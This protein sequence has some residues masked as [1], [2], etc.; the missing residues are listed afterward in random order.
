MA[1]TNWIKLEYLTL[2]GWRSIND[3]EDFRPTPVNVLIGPNGA[4]K[5]NFI[6]F[7]NFLSYLLQGKLQTRVQELGRASD[8]LFDGPAVTQQ[9]EA[10]FGLRTS[11]GL[12]EYCFKLQFAKPD[13]L[14]F[15]EEG[16]RF[17]P[18]DCDLESVD[19]T[20]MGGGHAESKLVDRTDRTAST[21]R[22]LLKQLIVYQFHNTTDTASI[23]LSWSADDGRHLK[24]NAQNLGSFLHHLKEHQ[25]PY[26]NRI[27]LYLKTVLPFL[28]DLELEPEYGKILLS[29]TENG[30]DKVFNAGQASDG[31]LRILALFT[32]LGQNPKS[33]PSVMFIDEPELGLHPAAIDAVAGLIK[34]A[35]KH[36]QMFISTQSVSMVNNFSPDDVVVVERI[37]RESTYKRQ[38]VDD[39]EAYLEE[40][41]T[42]QIWDMNIMGGRP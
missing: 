1:A 15:A 12:N 38:S 29:W 33:L 7:F 31:M 41:S 6:T 30:S 3:M 36:C 42:G 4:G 5:S 21:L 17:C 25:L 28:D 8:I 35:S 32:L 14:F 22:N 40:F 27:K 9:M 18:N 10:A 20:W 37:G 16:F 2:K 19:W 26:Y 11:A 24:A 39:L 34:A 13:N 23:R